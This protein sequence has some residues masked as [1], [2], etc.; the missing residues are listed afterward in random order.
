MEKDQWEEDLV[1]LGR[2]GSRGE[3]EKACPHAVS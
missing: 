1:G 3:V 2:N